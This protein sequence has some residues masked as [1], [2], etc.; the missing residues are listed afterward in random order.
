MLFVGW[1]SLKG[2]WTWS[3]M[4]LMVEHP[5]P[6]PDTVMSL[7]GA[8]LG[9]H[10]GKHRSTLVAQIKN[11]PTMQETRVR[12]LSPEDRLEQEMATHSSVPVWEIPGTKEPGRLQSKRLQMVRYY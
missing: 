12:S 6:L 1:E 2:K 11:P 8:A 3:Q 10:L 9:E 7:M 4:Y 5:R